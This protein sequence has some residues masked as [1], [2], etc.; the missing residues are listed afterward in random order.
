MPDAVA[1]SWKLGSYCFLPR[2]LCRVQTQLYTKVA[3]G[4]AK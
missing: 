1:G 2:R 4:D 3:E